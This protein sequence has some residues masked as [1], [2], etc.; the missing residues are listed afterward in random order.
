[1][2]SL[3]NRKNIP[4]LR[5][6][7]FHG[8]W[9][10]IEL[11]ELGHVI[12]G[13]S[14]RPKGDSRYYGGDV[15]R[16]MVQDVTRDGKYVTPSID[17]LTEEGAK[18]SRPCKAG[19]LTIVCSG[20]VGIVSFLAVDACIH[21]GFMALIDID[22]SKIDKDFLYHQLGTLRDTFEQNATHGGV[23]TNLT[24]TTL[25]E[26]EVRYTSLSEQRKIADFLGTAD[27]KLN[28]LRRKQELLS[29][30]KRGVMQ[31][32]FTQQI[33]FTQDD[34]RPF[35]AWKRKKIGAVAKV[36]GGFAFKSTNF[37]DRGVPVIRIS[38]IPIQ[39]NTIDLS[40]AT[41]HAPLQ[42][43]KNFTVK[44][45]Q[46]LIALSGATTGKTAVY[47]DQQQAY[48]NQRVGLFVGNEATLY[49][50]FLIHFVSSSLFSR[51]LDAELVAGA[52]PN[53]STK[54]IESFIIDMPNLP[55]QQKLADFLT[56]IDDKITAVNQQIAHMETFKKGLLQQMFV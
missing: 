55:E 43:A 45:G 26:F 29:Q 14:P 2:T 6:E 16:L 49:Y 5:F 7:Q 28:A 23:F 15:P 17:F 44:Q 36:L 31:K 22:E 3:A 38:D 25:K 41:H 48:V 4:E 12:R 47:R 1:M 40:N 54:N 11:Q 20:T 46:M 24:T 9:G 39:S 33:R 51:Q 30:Y 50:P 34:G 52:Q 53:I 56:A 21:D 8:D 10:V 13:A 18:L 37:Q 19:T 27:S 32:L 35:P 42:K